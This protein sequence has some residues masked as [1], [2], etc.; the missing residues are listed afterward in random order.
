MTAGIWFAMCPAGRAIGLEAL[1]EE[2]GKLKGRRA[3]VEGGQL[4]VE[5][6]EAAEVIVSYQH[7]K[8]V[9]AEAAEIAGRSDRADRDQLAAYDARYEITFEMHE[10]DTVYNTVVSL[11]SRL[12]KQC[13][14]VIY[15]TNNARF[16]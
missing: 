3:W 4:Y 10:A 11:S 5:V 16:P 14:A 15:D 7:G 8:A 12:E 2:I 1:S 13:G 6:D 9:R